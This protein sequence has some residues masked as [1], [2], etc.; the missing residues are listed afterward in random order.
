MQFSF[1]GIRPMTPHNQTRLPASSHRLCLF[2]VA[3]LIA[4]RKFS[5]LFRCL[6]IIHFLWF[7]CLTICSVSLYKSSLCGMFKRCFPHRS[8]DYIITVQFISQ[9]LF[10]K[11]II[12]FFQNIILFRSPTISSSILFSYNNFSIFDSHIC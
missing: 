12:C 10:C 8:E 1:A 9:H 5:G 2:V 4:S 6:I 3:R 7:M 11:K